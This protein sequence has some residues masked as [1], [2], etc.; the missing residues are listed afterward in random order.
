LSAPTAVVGFIV[1]P[2][3]FLVFDLALRSNW[4]TGVNA[5]GV[6]VN[7]RRTISYTVNTFVVREANMGIVVLAVNVFCTA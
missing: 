4:G 7:A 1:V 3:S 2:F 5:R 6:L